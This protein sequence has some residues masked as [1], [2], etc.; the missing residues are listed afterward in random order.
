MTLI[1][2]WDC[3]TSIFATNSHKAT[4]IAGVKSQ[5]KLL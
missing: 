4:I 2:W 1:V 5:F 3:Q